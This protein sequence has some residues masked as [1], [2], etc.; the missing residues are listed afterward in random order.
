MKKYFDLFIVSLI[1]LSACNTQKSIG[2]Q[3]PDTTRATTEIPDET[4]NLDTVVVAPE[5]SGE[6]EMQEDLAEETLPNTLPVYNP[7]NTRQNDLLHTKL[8]LRFDWEKQQV[9]GKATLKFKPYFRAVSSLT[10][11]AKDFEF[12]KITFEGKNDP[13]KYKYENGALEI[14]LG[15]S[16]K[17]NEEYS[18]YIEYIASPAETGGSEAITSDQGLFFINP[19]GEDPEKPQQIWTQGE[20]NWNS[21]WFPTIDHPNERCTQEVSLTVADKYVTLSNGLLVSSKKNADG[22]RTDYWKMDKP[23]APYLFMVAVGEYA[24]VKDKWKDV[25]LEY[26]VEKKYADYAKAIFAHT[27]EMLDFFSTKTGLKYPWQKLSQIVVRDYVSGAM[28]NT[29]AIVYGEFV[30]KT[31]RELIDNDNDYIV[32]HE[33]FHHWFGDYV[34]CESWAN[35]TMNEGFAN[36]SEYLWFEHKYGAD[37]ADFHLL[38]EWSGYIGSAGGGNV[39]PLIHFGYNNNEDMFDAHSYNKG[40]ATL[41]MLRNYVGDEAFWMALNKYL[42]DNAYKSVEVHNLRLAF[43]EVTGEDLNWF[44]N[45]WYLAAGHPI[46]NINYA[47]DEANQLLSLSVEQQQSTEGGVPAIFQLPVNVDIYSADGKPQR[48]RILVNERNQTFTFPMSQKPNL[49]TFDADRMLLCEKTENKT[50]EEYI[51]QFYN[52]PKFYD[53]YEALT[54]LIESENPAARD[55]MRAGLKDKFWVIREIALN[56]LLQEDID[57]ATKAVLRNM[58]TNDPNAQMRMSAIDKLSELEDEALLEIAKKAVEKDSAYNVIA[59]GLQALSTL[60]PQTALEQAKKL[61][62]EKN[63]DILLVV[64]NVYGENGSTQNLAF[65]ER[66]FENTDGYTALYFIENYQKL[67][68]KGEAS[69][70]WAGVENLKKMALDQQQS[71]WR[72]FASTKSLNDLGN[73]YNAAAKEQSDSTQQEKLMTYVTKLSE[74]IETIKSAETNSQLIALYSQMVITE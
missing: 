2:N 49:V 28:E 21:R 45:Q 69:T 53:R 54:A 7:S 52:A 43:E 60:E 62:N 42:T 41:H 33:I 29:T 61:E 12:Q 72:R 25:P 11:D 39:H 59:S 1:L 22:T 17:K 8:D 58:A 34:T 66:N 15:R 23:H 68:K 63:D 31:N 44:F 36:Y 3:S 65:F 47:Y 24:V 26:Y 64:S 10:L 32:A 37:R 71:L 56:Q 50:E 51:F 67:F 38:N 74:I 16:F 55:I 19:K 30:Q 57:E 40:G 73:E 5:W 35:L 70:L 20:T 9:I 18:I 46:L 4:R 6:E 13:L 14:D 27:P 48:T